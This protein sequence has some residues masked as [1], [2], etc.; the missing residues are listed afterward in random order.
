M[1]TKLPD[2]YAQAAYLSLPQKRRLRQGLNMFAFLL[3]GALVALG[4]RWK[5]FRGLSDLLSGGLGA[6]LLWALVL[7][8]ALFACVYLHGLTHALFLRLFSG[9]PALTARKGLRLFVGTAAYLRRGAYLCAVLLPILS[10]TAILLPLCVLW[11]GARFWFAYGILVTQVCGALDDFWF[12][13]LAFRFGKD[14]RF[15]YR[16]F[17]VGV[18]TEGV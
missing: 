9:M 16:G 3:T 1:D 6:Y 4:W 15:L 7:C 13:S 2:G 5:S 12:A 10:W 18:Y 17:A 11:Q 14:A 8:A